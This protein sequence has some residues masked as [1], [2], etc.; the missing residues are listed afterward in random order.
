MTLFVTEVDRDAHIRYLTM[1]GCCPQEIVDNLLF[2]HGEIFT[3][4][5]VRRVIAERLS[6]TQTDVA[7]Y[8]EISW[9]ISRY[10]R[11]DYYDSQRG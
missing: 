9:R 8:K 3:P 5:E 4:A 1:L 7:E 2:Q 6:P 10:G 11:T